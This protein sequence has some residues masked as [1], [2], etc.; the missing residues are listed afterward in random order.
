[1]RLALTYIVV[2]AVLCAPAAGADRLTWTKIRYVGGTV[3]IKTR[4]DDWNAKL[5]VS[6]NP[7]L[8]TISIAPAKLFTPMQRIRIK[9]VQVI[10]LCQGPGSWARGG[11]VSGA[12]RPPEP[13]T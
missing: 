13:P 3:D 8:I 6:A 1:M 9:P 2:G 10:G 4:P 12:H 11:G 5:T 7:D